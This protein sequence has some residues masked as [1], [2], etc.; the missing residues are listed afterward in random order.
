FNLLTAALCVFLIEPKG[1]LR[2]LSSPAG[3]HATVFGAWPRAVLAPFAAVV[4]LV[5]AQQF[6]EET[7]GLGLPWPAPAVWLARAASPLRSI[8]TYGLF[9]VM[10]TTRPEI[11]IEGSPDGETWRPYEFR[12]KPGNPARRPSFVAPHQPRLDWQMWFAALGSCEESPWLARLFERLLE[13]SPPVVGLL[14]DNPF[15][16]RPPRYVR[17]LVYDYHFT[18]LA[19]RRRTGDW[20]RRQLQGEFCPIVSRPGDTAP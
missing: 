6:S 19:T 14:G 16:E 2:R 4:V 1:R 20:W 11:V 18:D 9:A 8:N 5:S 10:T 7:L 15:P 17:A 3:E 13:G 12:Y